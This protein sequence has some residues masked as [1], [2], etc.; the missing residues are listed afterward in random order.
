[1]VRGRLD[2]GLQHLAN[3]T[4]T[5]S[6][7]PITGP[8]D[9]IAAHVDGAFVVVVRLNGGK[10]RR[11]C[12]LTVAAAERH[13]RRAQ[14]AGHNADVFLAELKPLWKVVGGTVLS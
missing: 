14:D 12:F 1:M 2:N 9:D 11:R 4:N 13:A 10:Y 8:L 3:P 7:I 6:L 5:V